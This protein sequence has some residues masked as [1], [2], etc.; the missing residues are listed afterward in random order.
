MCLP[1]NQ[2]VFLTKYFASFL[3]ADMQKLAPKKNSPQLTRTIYS[4]TYSG[5]LK[6]KTHMSIDMLEIELTHISRHATL[7]F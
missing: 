1:Y 3:I 7:M 2:C 6:K 4:L 5:L